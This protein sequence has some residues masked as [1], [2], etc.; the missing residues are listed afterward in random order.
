MYTY[1]APAGGGGLVRFPVGGGIE[2]GNCPVA[3]WAHAWLLPHL[4]KQ[5]PQ[6][7]NGYALTPPHGSFTVN[8][9][10]GPRSHV[11]I[12]GV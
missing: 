12:L 7:L 9:G 1:G 5:G 2:S 6:L 10:C 8:H 11:N 4:V 3:P